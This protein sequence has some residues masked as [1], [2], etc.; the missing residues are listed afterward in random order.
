MIFNFNPIP[1]LT[2][3][4]EPSN[5]RESI[6]INRHSRHNSKEV[7]REARVV[8]QYVKDVET[9]FELAIFKADPKL[10]YEE[11]FVYFLNE[12]RRKCKA[13]AARRFKNVS[14]NE[15]HFINKYAPK[16]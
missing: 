3:I 13:V 2:P 14:I 16:A 5:E 15:S 6:A 7:Q 10:S 1:E 11:L 9:K 12:W 4:K 8:E